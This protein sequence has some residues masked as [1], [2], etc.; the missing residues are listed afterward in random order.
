MCR[1]KRE[2]ERKEGGQRVMGQRSRG[3]EKGGA[4]WRDGRDKE[5]DGKRRRRIWT[6][7]D[8]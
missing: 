2:G 3:T 6:D 1:I 8:R 5:I 7:R 4:R